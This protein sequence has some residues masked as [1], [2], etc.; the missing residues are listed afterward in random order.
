M[1]EV[2][3]IIIHAFKKG[4]D[5]AR[6]NIETMKLIVE[7]IILIGISGLIACAQTQA[8]GPET[9]ADAVLITP[10]HLKE[11]VGIEWYLKRMKINN[12]TISLIK[13]AQITFSYDANGKVAG[14]ASLNRYFGGFNLKEDGEII[15]SKAFGMTR[16]AGPPELMDQEAKFMQAL[17]LTTRLYLKK[18]M[19]VL[20]STDQ[21][22]V[23]EF[24]KN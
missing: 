24:D 3:L 11:I 19:L 23:L 8:G 15:W 14:V 10:E 18:E 5:R 4:D 16:M 22:T 2:I 7:L 9:S 6:K 12:Q 20:T 21:A 13:D 1:P 17:P